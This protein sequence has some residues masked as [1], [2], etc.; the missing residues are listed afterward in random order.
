MLISLLKPFAF[1]HK[2]NGTEIASGFH[3]RVDTASKTSSVSKMCGLVVGFLLFLF[4]W[5]GFIL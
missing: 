4:V 1:D 5:F 2:R 3:I